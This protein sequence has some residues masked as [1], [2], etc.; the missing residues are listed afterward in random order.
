M[1]IWNR[2]SKPQIQ[3]LV[4]LLILF[5]LM[6]CGC[7]GKVNETEL[8][9]YIK[10]PKNGLF[11]EKSVNGTTYQVYYRPSGFIVKQMLSTSDTVTAK[12]VDSLKKVTGKNLYFILSISRN[13]TDALESFANDRPTYSAMVQQMAF[14][15]YDQVVLTSD[16]SDTLRLVDYV[17]PRTYGFANAANMLFSFEKKDL[18]KYEWLSLLV[19]DFGLKTGDVRFKFYTKDILDTPELNIELNNK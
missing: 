3:S 7:K 6:L 10:N 17:Y 5:V 15:L 14:G 2:K 8:A 19:K 11:L 4:L 18:R 16:H 1:N 9:D 12:V 13:G